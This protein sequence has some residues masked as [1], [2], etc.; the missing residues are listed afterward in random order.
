ME[1]I[2]L[3]NR[4]HSRDEGKILHAGGR[5]NDLR[6]K[7]SR[8]EQIQKNNNT[9]SYLQLEQALDSIICLLPYFTSAQKE[10]QANIMANMAA[11]HYSVSVKEMLPMETQDASSQ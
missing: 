1:S 9:G 6:L 4:T 10:S 2:P 7:R 5:L 3:I 11:L 8:D